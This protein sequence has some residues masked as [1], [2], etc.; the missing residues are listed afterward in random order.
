MTKQRKKTEKDIQRG[1]SEIT[2]AVLA[3][4]DAIVATDIGAGLLGELRA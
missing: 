4:L 1:I 2:D 3:G